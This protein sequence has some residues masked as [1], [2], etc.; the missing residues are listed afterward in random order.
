MLDYP[1]VPRWIP[2]IRVHIKVPFTWLLIPLRCHR[3][4]SL[5]LNTAWRLFVLGVFLVRIFPHSDWIRR[6]TSYLSVF[7]SKTGKYGP[8]KLRI[9]TLFTQCDLVFSTVLVLSI[10]SAF[11]HFLLLLFFLM[12]QFWGIT[13]IFIVLFHHFQ[14]D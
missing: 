5:R 3:E 2:P 12:T 11:M 4:K 10:C 14:L 9:R 13:A 1:L 6:Y 7:S 8:E